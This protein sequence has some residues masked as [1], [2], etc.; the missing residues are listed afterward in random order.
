MHQAE[1]SRAEATARM[2]ICILFVGSSGCLLLNACKQQQPEN[3]T[4]AVNNAAY[5]ESASITRYR[6]PWPQQPTQLTLGITALLSLC[7]NLCAGLAHQAQQASSQAWKSA[8]P[9]TPD[10]SPTATAKP[11]VHPVPWVTLLAKLDRTSARHVPREPLQKRPPPSAAPSVQLDFIPPASAPA[12]V[13]RA[14]PV[15]LQTQPV[16][17]R[18]CNAPPERTPL[19]PLRIQ[20]SLAWSARLDLSATSQDQRSVSCVLPDSIR[21]RHARRPAATARWVRTVRPK[22]APG[23]CRASQGLP[24]LQ[25]AATMLGLAA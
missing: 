16:P 25:P 10:T 15:R 18:A 3:E 17:T 19:G 6:H 13:C 24:R 4:A 23:A 22:A 1:N 7:S 12:S 20:V 14:R 11:P 21:T 2:G 8:N 9:A 5:S